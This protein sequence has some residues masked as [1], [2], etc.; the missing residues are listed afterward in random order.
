MAICNAR[1]G[2]ACG[3]L[4]VRIARGLQRFPPTMWFQRL[5]LHHAQH[6]RRVG[7]LVRLLHRREISPPAGLRHIDI[8]EVLSLDGPEP[9]VSV[10]QPA[11][12]LRQ[13]GE[14][15]RAPK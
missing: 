6:R 14:F 5:I 1:A 7:S 8:G 9:P 11:L 13:A 2:T 4:S 12:E 15:L 3:P 10:P